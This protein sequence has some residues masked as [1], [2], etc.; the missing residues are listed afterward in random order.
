MDANV[1]ERIT[2]QLAAQEGHVGFYF[3]NLTTGEEIN[4]HQDEQFLAASVI[5]LPIFMSI[6][7]WCSEG[8][9]SMDENIQVKQADKMPICGAL[10]LF[11]DEPTVD[12]RTLCNLMISL[13]DNTATNV[14]IKRFGIAQLTEE[15]HKIGLSGT[16]LNRLLFDESACAK[17]LENKIVPREMG[18]L[19]EQVYHR[20]FANAQVSAEIED[21]LFLQQINHKICGIIGEEVPIAHKTGEDEDLSND[22]GL[23]YAKQ[24]FIVCFAGHDTNVPQWE[25]AIRK[26]S[27]ELFEACGGSGKSQ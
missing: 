7:K 4:Y 10:T 19:L 25:D 13:S 11:T 1:L 17:G 18:M 21:T 6:A 15:F 20:S 22:V 5:K 23:V 24:P 8:K 26:I 27:A 9:A 3:K 2:T 12:V 14:L 16:E